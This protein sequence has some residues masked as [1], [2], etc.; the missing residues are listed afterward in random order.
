MRF[1][2]GF[3]GGSAPLQFPQLYVQRYWV[4][5][6]G[7]TPA[8]APGL[9]ASGLPMAYLLSKSHHFPGHAASHGHAASV[10]GW[11]AA[12]VAPSRLRALPIVILHLG[13]LVCATTV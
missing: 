2:N 3:V 12:G 13:P 5:G 9:R 8:Q 1:Y 10:F 7:E 11:C 4:R 6:L